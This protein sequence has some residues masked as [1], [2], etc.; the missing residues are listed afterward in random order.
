MGDDIVGD[1][2]ILERGPWGA[3][4]LIPGGE[5]D[6]EPVLGVRPHV[7]QDVPI[8]QDVAGVLNF[9]QVLHQP[10]RTR[11]LPCHRPGQVVPPDLDI[12]RDKP[13]LGRVLAAEVDALA[14]RFDVVV[15]DLQGTRPVPHG[16]PVCVRVGRRD[17][18]R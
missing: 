1:R 8:H 7:L 2:D 15:H 6:R 12:G 10:M 3:S 5:D 18:L 9:K 11:S 16:Y 14:R 13:L 17:P 4:G